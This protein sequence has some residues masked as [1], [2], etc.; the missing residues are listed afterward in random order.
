MAAKTKQCGK[1]RVTKPVSEYNRNSTTVDQLQWQCK[2]C[3]REYGRKQTEKRR[4]AKMQ[5]TP[6]R[7][8]PTKRT[9][10]RVRVDLVRKC[11]AEVSRGLDYN[12]ALTDQQC[13]EAVL[14]TVL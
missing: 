7:Q 3:F 9:P 10:I 5:S 12:V 14:K 2:S 4:A 13:V 11:R 1:C 6:K 8:R